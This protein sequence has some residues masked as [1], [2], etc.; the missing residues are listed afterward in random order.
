MVAWYFRCQSHH[1]KQPCTKSKIR[2]DLPRRIYYTRLDAITAQF[3]ETR[4]WSASHSSNSEIK[5]RDNRLPI[6]LQ[7]ACNIITGHHRLLAIFMQPPRNRVSPPID[8]ATI[9]KQ[10]SIRE[11]PLA[12]SFSNL[13]EEG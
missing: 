4:D 3:V 12:S 13:L 8:R 6:T 9:G 2:D 10:I 7:R 11:F 5:I 1:S